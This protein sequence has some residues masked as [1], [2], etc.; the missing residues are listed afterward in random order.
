MQADQ[1]STFGFVCSA[2]GR[3]NKASSDAFK[4]V[5][6]DWEVDINMEGHTT[7][8][9]PSLYCVCGVRCC[10]YDMCFRMFD[11]ESSLRTCRKESE[12]LG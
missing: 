7:L 2:C 10:L 4:L 1:R 3:S 9:F 6:P 12:S 5:K 11:K 8:E